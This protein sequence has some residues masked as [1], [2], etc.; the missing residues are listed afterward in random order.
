MKLS[1]AEGPLLTAYV[2]V[3][4]AH[5]F[6]VQLVASLLRD[7][8]G[9]GIKPFSSLSD[10]RRRTA[11]AKERLTTSTVGEHSLAPLVSG[12]K[13]SAAPGS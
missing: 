2:R 3:T 10:T 7:A 1:S 13:L 8:A 11:H 4:L 9:R 6:V 5:S 12:P